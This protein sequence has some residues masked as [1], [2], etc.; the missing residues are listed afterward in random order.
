MIIKTEM[1]IVTEVMIAASSIALDRRKKNIAGV[2]IF[3]HIL[4]TR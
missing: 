1:D 3:L 2:D 4:E